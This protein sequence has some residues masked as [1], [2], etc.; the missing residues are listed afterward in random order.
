M[1]FG[2][3]GAAVFSASVSSGL[4]GGEIELRIDSLAGTKIG[5]LP[6]SNTGGWDNWKLK[7]TSVDNASGVH[8]LFLIFR[9]NP[10]EKLFNF[11][12]WKFEEKN[13]KNELVAINASVQKF[14]IDIVSSL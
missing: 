5:S 3:K 14:K 2:Y 6:I 8:D 7:S 11:D 1:D 9:G 10:G 13:Q 4:N 12:Y